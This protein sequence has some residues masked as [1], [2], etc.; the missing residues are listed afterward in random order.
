[1]IA[2][3]STLVIHAGALGDFVL[4]LHAAER[5]RRCSPDGTLHSLCRSLLACHLAQCG[6]LGSWK[7]IEAQRWAPLWQ[8]TAHDTGDLRRFLASFDTVISFLGDATAPQSERLRDCFEGHLVTLDP[9]PRTQA[10]IVDHW[11]AGITATGLATAVS[12]SMCAPRRVTAAGIVIHPGSGGLDKCWPL[13]LYEELVDTLVDSP[14]DVSFML[15]PDEVE[16]HGPDLVDRLQRRA[17]VVYHDDL[18]AAATT[19]AATRLY[20]GND[21]GMTH[22]AALLG[23]PTIQIFMTTNPDVWR[24]LGPVTVLARPGV[25]EVMA[26]VTANRHE[27][28]PCSKVHWKDDRE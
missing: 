14:D 9:R 16:R 23:I 18:C 22:V 27:P 24:A 25:E 2:A 13:E 4:A 8:S 1:M 15:G 3:S 17:R 19:L 26:V 20:I 11:T 6:M 5:V 28:R 21:A 10:H 12:G 7:H